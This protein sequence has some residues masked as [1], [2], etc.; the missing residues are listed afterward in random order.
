MPVTQNNATL[1]RLQEVKRVHFAHGFRRGSDGDEAQLACG[2]ENGVAVSRV[3]RMNFIEKERHF[4][5]QRLA[6]VLAQ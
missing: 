1:L 2:D 6:G 5:E 3:E 4:A